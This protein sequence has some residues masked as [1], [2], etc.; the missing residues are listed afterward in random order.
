VEERAVTPKKL[1]ADAFT[2]LIGDHI[3]LRRDRHLK[4]G[5]WTRLVVLAKG[6]EQETRSLRLELLQER[7]NEIRG[8]LSTATP[9]LA[10]SSSTRSAMNWISNRRLITKSGKPSR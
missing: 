6:K 9:K 3:A 2:T 5:P 8:Q 4:I 10:K 1:M 7:L